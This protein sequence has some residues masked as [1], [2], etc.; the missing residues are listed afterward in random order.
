VK[1]SLAQGIAKLFSSKSKFREI[2]DE[3]KLW[4]FT[5]V[6]GKQSSIWD[7]GGVRYRASG[8]PSLLVKCPYCKQK[9]LQRI[10]KAQQSG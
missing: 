2:A 3:S 1:L 5:C 10:Y 6:C 8:N 7:I 4:L 9:S